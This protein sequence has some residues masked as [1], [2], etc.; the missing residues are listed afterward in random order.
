MTPTVAITR[1]KDDVEIRIRD[2]FRD[3]V[4]R[5]RPAWTLIHEDD[6]MGAYNVWTLRLH[7]D[8]A[9]VIVKGLIEAGVTP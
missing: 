2:S 8:E 1:S 4:L 6:A 5:N 3:Q 9:G 7:V